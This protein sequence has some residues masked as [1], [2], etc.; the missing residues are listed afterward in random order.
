MK[1][2]GSRR[3]LKATWER[4]ADAFSRK[5]LL[6]LVEE[7]T[8]T[9][10]SAA[11]SSRSSNEDVGVSSV[12]VSVAA[13]SSVLPKTMTCANCRHSSKSSRTSSLSGMV[14]EVSI[15]LPFSCRDC[16]VDAGSVDFETG[17]AIVDFCRPGHCG[18]I[19]LGRF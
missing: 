19:G 7:E 13:L 18:E 14:V 4:D 15:F 10:P 6:S 3:R 2:L 1:I 9:V 11:D 8:S 17:A 5:A 12:S 16:R